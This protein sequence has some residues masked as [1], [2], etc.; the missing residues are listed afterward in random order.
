MPSAED[1]MED[2]ELV[3][4]AKAG[5]LGGA[6]SQ[7]EPNSSQKSK[8]GKVRLKLFKIDIYFLLI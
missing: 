5:R 3:L 8:N 1:E 4:L 7:Q 2:A 6:K